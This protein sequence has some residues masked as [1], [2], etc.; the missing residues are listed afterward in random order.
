MFL[1][2]HNTFQDK[3]DEINPLKSLMMN[4]LFHMLL[5]NILLWFLMM[6]LYLISN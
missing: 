5:F 3:K 4:I 6:I 1:N 2:F